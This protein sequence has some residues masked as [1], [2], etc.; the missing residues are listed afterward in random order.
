MGAANQT[1]VTGRQLRAVGVASSRRRAREHRAIHFRSRGKDVH[2]ADIGELLRA[3]LLFPR[4]D[5]RRRPLK[6]EKGNARQAALYQ[7]QQPHHRGHR[8]NCKRQTHRRARR[9][10]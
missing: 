3:R 2:A 4:E 1:A 6:H 10:S 8:Q 9:R 7:R 5:G